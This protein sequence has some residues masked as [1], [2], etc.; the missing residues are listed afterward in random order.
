MQVHDLISNHTATVQLINPPNKAVHTYS[1]QK[2]GVDW[3]HTNNT[4][5]DVTIQPGRMNTVIFLDTGK[6]QEYRH[7]MKGPNKPKWKRYFGNEIGR[8]FQGIQYIEG[9][10]TCFFIHNN[11]VPKGSKV[12]YSSIV[13]NIR[14]QKTEN[15]RVRL[16]VGGDKLSYEDPVSTS[17]A[18][19][20]SISIWCVQDAVPTEF[21]FC[22]I[23]CGGGD[24]A[25][26]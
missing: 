3:A 14:P 20:L 25:L 6:L 19:Q 4:T 7:V 9:T 15:H 16:I 23:S 2:V 18:Q 24:W 1:V 10:N 5:E 26:I 13:C 22:Q 8:L 17:T 12:T 11:E 21:G